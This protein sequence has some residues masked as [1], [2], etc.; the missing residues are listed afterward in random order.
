MKIAHLLSVAFLALVAPAWA[1]SLPAPSSTPILVVSGE[2]GVTNVDGTAQFD[3][4]MLEQMMD[5]SFETKTPWHDGP[6]LFEGISMTTL[7]D[8]VGATG[9][10]LTVTALNDYVTDIPVSDFE[11][12]GTLLALKRNGEFMSV[13]DKGPLFIIYPFDNSEELR[14]QT[15]FGRSAWQVAK[16]AVK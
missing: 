5:S 10:M 6:S 12:F 7:M 2:I 8:A 4:A 1:A 11:Q 13:R 3:R 16:I 14:S 9:D 15:Y